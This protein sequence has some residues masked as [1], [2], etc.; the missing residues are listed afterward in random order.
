MIRGIFDN[1]FANYTSP[2]FFGLNPWRR[3]R[4]LPGAHGA[5]PLRRRAAACLAVVL[6]P[7]RAPRVAMA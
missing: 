7:P 1:R 4:F 6:L 3:P 5:D 2:F